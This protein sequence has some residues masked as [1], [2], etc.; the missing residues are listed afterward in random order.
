MGEIRAAIESSSLPPATKQMI[1]AL[2]FAQSGKIRNVKTKEHPEQNYSRNDNAE[3]AHL[4]IYPCNI[5]AWL[6]K[7]RYA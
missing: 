1:P 6:A 3:W 2:P 4:S 5:F 7:Y